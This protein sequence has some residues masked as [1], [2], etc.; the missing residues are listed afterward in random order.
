MRSADE[1]DVVLRLCE[2]GL[3]DKTVSEL[4]GVPR[5]TVRDWRCGRVPRANRLHACTHDDLPEEEYAYLLGIYLG[6]GCLSGHPRGVWRLRVACDS[7]YPEMIDAIGHA[8]VCVRGR[9]HAAVHQ[10]PGRCVEVAMY[11]KHWPCLFPQHGR[12]PKWSRNIE[13]HDWQQSIVERERAAFLCGLIDSDGC[14]ITATYHER[15]GI[16]RRYGRYV[17]SNRSEQI[18]KLFT[19]SLDALGIHWTRANFKD[20]AVARQRDV[21]ELDR[22]IGPKA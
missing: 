21:R 17:F 1:V 2:S 13:L 8:M 16:T 9:G 12:G 4:T 14:R 19:D 11:W 5:S 6:D 20:T 10:R 18:H 7:Q 3:D 15:S 22:F